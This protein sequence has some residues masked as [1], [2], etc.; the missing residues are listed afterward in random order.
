VQ[1]KKLPTNAD[2]CRVRIRRQTTFEQFSQ[3]AF[4]PYF[5][6]FSH[7][8]ESFC[9]NREGVFAS[10]ARYQLHL[11]QWNQ[12]SCEFLTT[13]WPHSAKTSKNFGYGWT[14]K[15]KEE[16]PPA[17]Q[18]ISRSRG[19]SNS[20]R[21]ARMNSMGGCPGLCF[22]GQFN[23]EMARS[24]TGVEPFNLAWHSASSERSYRGRDEHTLQEHIIFHPFASAEQARAT[25][26]ALRPLAPKAT[27]ARDLLHFQ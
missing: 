23:G 14:L 27:Y 1:A 6:R 8:F 4:H 24:P 10:R 7:H 3:P 25:N 21:D 5:M 11:I 2:K 19:C 9:E 20:R 16:R 15:M 12:W 13:Q 18:Q 26:E 17:S 22:C